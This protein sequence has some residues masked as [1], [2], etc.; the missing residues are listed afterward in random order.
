MQALAKARLTTLIANPNVLHKQGQI[1]KHSLIDLIKN[2]RTKEI[3]NYVSNGTS[4][5]CSLF[6][7]LNGNFNFIN[8]IQEKLEP[9]S[10][11]LSKVAFS[12][13]SLSGS[14]DF[15]QKKNILPLIG[16]LIA[17]PTAALSSGYNFWLSLGLS[18]GLSNFIVITDQ[19]EIVDKNGEP[20]LDKDGNTQIINGDFGK[21]GW[22]FGFSTTLKESFKMIKELF[23][24]PSR[25]KKISHSILIGSLVEM[26]GPIIGLFGL[27]TVGSAIRNTATVACE[28]SMMLHKELDERGKSKRNNGFMIDLK[29]SIAQSGLLWVA[30]SLIDLLKRFDYFSSKVNN[31]THLALFLDR[32]ASIRFNQG[33]LNIK[34]KH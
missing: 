22:W 25:I 27:K 5:A 29:S 34:A 28:A 6:A 12:I 30:T 24:K 10:E 16:Y 3:I 17:A 11:W 7:F 31:L 1:Q 2:K 8:N 19:R 18:S 26:L 33:V 20:I 9:L 14:V 23:Q 32:L 4:S 13:V 21:R 15:W